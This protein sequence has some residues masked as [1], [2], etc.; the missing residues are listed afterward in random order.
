M[1]AE[2]PGCPAC[3]RQTDHRLVAVTA[4]TAAEV[5]IRRDKQTKVKLAAYLLTAPLLR[6]RYNSDTL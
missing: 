5:L 4:P 1:P 6:Y 3:H 2:A